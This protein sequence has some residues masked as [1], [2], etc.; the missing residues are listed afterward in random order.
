MLLRIFTN[1]IKTAIMINK[2]QI[3]EKLASIPIEKIAAA[4]NFTSRTG[5]KVTP[6]NFIL[7]FFASI[8]R[9]RHTIGN[10][11]GEL[12]LLIR[13]TVSYNG[14]KKAQNKARAKF[15]KGLLEAVLG[16]QLDQAARTRVKTCLLEPFGRVFIEDSTCIALPERLH[17]F[18]PGA[19]SKT[20]KAATAKIQLRQELKSGSYVKMAL[21]HFRN[22]DQSFAADILGIL[23][24]GDL[25]IRDLGYAVL[26]VFEKIGELNAFYISRLRYGTNL[27]DIGTGEQVNLG[28]LLR[29]A[30]R[31]KLTTVEL[32][33]HVGKK[34]K[35]PA[36]V[37]AIKCP[38]GVTRQRRKRARN[39]RSASANH[40][41]D[42][43]ELLGWTIFFT[44]VSKETLP[45]QQLL[46]AYG[47]RWRI[48][49]VFKCWKSHFKMDRLFDTQTKLTAEQV[50][51]TFY[52]FLVW[53]TLFFARTYDYYLLKVY[54]KK[55]KILSLLKFAKFIKEHLT[56]LL[57]D[58]DSDFWIE[59]LAYYCTY[60]KQKGR[61]NFCEQVY[62]FN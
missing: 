13:R 14:L 25:V 21:K 47:Y 5:G 53:L 35:L 19:H 36:R 56:E 26:D 24:K 30:S 38:P 17:R 33:V 23:K 3:S 8:Q 44:N 59:H 60:K 61:L 55:K 1:S 50:E 28:K 58:P 31:N 27:Y 57:L 12:S 41:K 46:E 49:I 9:E 39:D 52:L 62:L 7:S 22:N 43:I 54:A 6:L 37:C 40:S 4:A 42:Y 16:T 11:A 34:K 51:I 29:K 2:N 48:E 45:A 10:W 32:F 20:G 18:F 15:A